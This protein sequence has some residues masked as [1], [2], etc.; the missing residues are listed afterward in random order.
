MAV[1]SKSYQS[2]AQRSAQ[3][4]T[5]NDMQRDPAHWCLADFVSKLRYV[6]KNSNRSNGKKKLLKENEYEE[7]NYDTLSDDDNGN[8]SDYRADDGSQLIVLRKQKVIC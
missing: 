3:A 7:M 5:S 4:T 8:E 6:S 1:I 2:R